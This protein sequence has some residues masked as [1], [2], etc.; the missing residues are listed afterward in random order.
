MAQ[1]WAWA[2]MAAD[3]GVTRAVRRVLVGQ[4]G[5][6]PRNGLLHLLDEEGFRVVAE[7]AAT[8]DIVQLVGEVR[9][10]IVVLDLEDPRTPEVATQLTAEFPAVSVIAWSSGEPTMR[11][12]PPF[13]H[14]ESYTARLTAG[15]LGAALKT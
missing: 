4:F 9:P 3:R 10:E 2:D 8:S 14:G 7:A 5:E 11:V 1:G 12:F 6:I 13:H 15:A